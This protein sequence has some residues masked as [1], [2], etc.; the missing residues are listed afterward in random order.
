MAEDEA[1]TFFVEPP[2]SGRRRSSV[3]RSSTPTAEECDVEA[4]AIEAYAAVAPRTAAKP[5]KATRASLGVSPMEL[6]VCCV[7]V[8]LDCC[9]PV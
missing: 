8:H 1:R 3:A 9:P 6:Q 5:A 4:W 7:H 2:S